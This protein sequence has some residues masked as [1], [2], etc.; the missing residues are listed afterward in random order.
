MMM[1][2]KTVPNNMP[3]ADAAPIVRL[4]KAPAPLAKMSGINPA[5]NAN[6]VMSMGLNRIFAPSIA[7]CNGVSPSLCFKE[8]NSTINIA[9]LPNSPISITIAIWA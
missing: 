9:F 3:P 2:P 8:A 6:D 1:T 5:I 7:A 4:P